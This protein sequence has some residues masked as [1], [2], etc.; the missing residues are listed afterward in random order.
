MKQANKI[1][2]LFSLMGGLGIVIAASVGVYS[3]SRLESYLNRAIQSRYELMH[4]TLKD[5]RFADMDESCG[6]SKGPETWGLIDKLGYV[7]GI[8]R[9]EGNFQRNI[10]GIVTFVRNN[11]DLIIKITSS[12]REQF[13]LLIEK[14]G[15]G[16]EPLL[17]TEERDNII[18]YSAEILDGNFAHRNEVV[19]LSKKY[20]KSF[21]DCKIT[22]EQFS[23]LLDFM[24]N[25]MVSGLHKIPDNI[26]FTV[27]GSNGAI[28]DSRNA[29]GA[30]KGLVGIF[31]WVRDNYRF[32]SSF[33]V[34]PN[35]F[36]ND[37][38]FSR[39]HTH[40]IND[41]NPDPSKP[42]KA[43]TYLEGPNVLFSQVNDVVLVYTI[44]R[45][46]STEVYRFKIG[47]Q[48]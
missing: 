47:N 33:E 12:D 19:E 21:R 22:P 29:R 37:S 25:Y 34:G 20:G 40:P 1:S 39:F 8:E 6:Q 41:K 46:A 15:K 17:A 36:K 48:K 42:D 43:N 2:T 13:G 5:T 30:Y 38:F 7:K 26:P 45:G 28:I 35:F 4:N 31:T 16:L 23:M 3:Y 14:T 18:K 27:L 10:D 11:Q 9:A 32:V 44:N 24:Q